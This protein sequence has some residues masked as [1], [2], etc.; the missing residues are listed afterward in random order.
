[1]DNKDAIFCCLIQEHSG[2]LLQQMKSACEAALEPLARIEDMVRTCFAFL[3]EHRA[4]YAM[5]VEMGGLAD[6]PTGQ[7]VGGAELASCQRAYATLFAQTIAD[8]MA[9]GR[10]REIGT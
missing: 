6:G 5:M 4:G 10:V 2:R 7:Q 3:E 8:A 9:A 1:F